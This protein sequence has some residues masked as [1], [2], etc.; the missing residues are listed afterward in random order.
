MRTLHGFLW[1]V[2]LLGFGV[3]ASAQLAERPLPSTRPVGIVYPSEVG[4]TTTNTLQDDDLTSRAVAEVDQTL[5][6]LGYQVMSR[7]EVIKKLVDAGANCA[8][9]V[10]NCPTSEVLSSL[11]LGAVVLIAI[12]WDRKPADITIEVTTADATGI[13]KAKLANDVTTQIPVLVDSALKDLK[14]GKAVEV[15]IYS[16]PIGAEV[17]LDGE[18]L[19]TA[20]VK[21][22]A[23]PGP[24]EVILTYPDY[25]TTSRHFDVPRGADG[26]LRVDVT[27]ERTAAS[28]ARAAD[29]PLPPPTRAT[30]AWDYALGGALALVGTALLISPIM[31][32]A[33]DGDCKD[34]ANAEGC[35]RI[36]FGWRSGLLMAGG[37]LALSGSVVLIA[38]TPI[39][40]SLSTDGENVHAQ[41]HG[42]F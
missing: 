37:V 35:E 25:V 28:A 1:L 26:P 14:N 27:L 7:A 9:G 32:L 24:H 13:A 12:W 5:R 8:A 29:V 4:R 16:V 6:R 41:L 3:P 19:G 11:D 31:T 20:P 39:R 40:A 21:A 38:T 33:R 23:R 17:R 30:P 42:T 34:E 18:L 2:F 22:S 36:D 15:G 10:Y